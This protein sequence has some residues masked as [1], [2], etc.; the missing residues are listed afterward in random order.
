[1]VLPVGCIDG[2]VLDR[3]AAVDHHAVTD[4]DGHMGGS[5]GV[6]GALEEDQ[7][8]GLGFASGDDGADVF[9]AI[10]SKSPDVPAVSTVIDDP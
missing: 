8:S 5:R 3:L 7:V 6:I 4:I 2:R 9:Q 1:M 10:R